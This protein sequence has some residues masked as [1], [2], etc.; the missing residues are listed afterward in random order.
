MRREAWGRLPAR[1]GRTREGGG[2]SL[3]ELPSLLGVIDVTAVQRPHVARGLA[4][5]FMELELE[6]EAEK[7]PGERRRGRLGVWQGWA[8]VSGSLSGRLALGY[9]RVSPS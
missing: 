4:E 3:Q 1:W 7:V 9:C 8:R 6:H 2:H 5:C